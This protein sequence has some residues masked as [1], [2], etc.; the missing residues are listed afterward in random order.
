[1]GGDAD[2]S[3]YA[4]D[5]SKVIY[6]KGCQRKRFVLNF[7]NMGRLKPSELLTQ[8]DIDRI[9]KMFQSPKKQTNRCK[10]YIQA[11]A[12]ICPVM[13]EKFYNIWS[14]EIDA[15]LINHEE[16]LM[17]HLPIL[18][19]KLHAAITMKYRILTFGLGNTND[20]PLDRFGNCNY[21]SPK[22]AVVFYDELERRYEL[23]NYSCYG[24]F[25]NNSL[26]ANNEIYQYIKR[27]ETEN[28]TENEVHEVEKEVN[29]QHTESS[30]DYPKINDSKRCRVSPLK[31]PFM[32]KGLKKCYCTPS[33][34]ESLTTGWE[35]SVPV[36]C[37]SVLRF[38]CVSFIFLIT[39]LPSDYIQ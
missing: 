3:G 13:L 29:I 11:R 12:L 33:N 34:F 21:I 14:P 5:Q 25:V 9:N 24:T 35:G 7:C 28:A 16:S 19:P 31:R 10:Q 32:K 20:V 15:I 8:N 17:G 38:G 4:Q 6:P 1:M 23:L 2:S 18:S 27:T 30:P 26:A 37:G 39:N 36:P 22:H